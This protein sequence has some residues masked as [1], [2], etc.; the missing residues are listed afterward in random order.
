M[1]RKVEE[2]ET[3]L[4]FESYRKQRTKADAHKIKKDRQEKRRHYDEQKFY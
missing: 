2:E 3:F 4:K 1:K